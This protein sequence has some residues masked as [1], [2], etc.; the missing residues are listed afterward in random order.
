MEN[1]FGSRAI[2]NEMK[3][4][5]LQKKLA[6][7]QTAIMKRYVIVFSYENMRRVVEPYHVG[8]LGG[9]IQLHSFQ[10]AGESTSGNTPQ[11]R[12]FVLNRMT[13]LKTQDIHFSVRSSYHPENSHYQDMV[14]SVFD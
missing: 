14:F 13:K 4:N 5:N 1:I 2:I 8:V 6:L 10:I 7:L 3:N 11:W 12:N 9:E